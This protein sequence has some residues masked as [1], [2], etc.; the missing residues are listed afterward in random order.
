[1]FSDFDPAQSPIQQPFAAP[2]LPVAGDIVM[3]LSSGRPKVTM[4]LVRGTAVANGGAAPAPLSPWQE[5]NFIQFPRFDNLNGVKH[6]VAG[7]LIG[8]DVG[9]GSTGGR[10]YNFATQGTAP[11]GAGQLIGNSTGTGGAGLTLT[12]LSGPSISPNNTKIAVAGNDT[13][14]VIVF[15]YTAGDTM[16]S[17]ASLSGARQTASAPLVTGSS[18]GTAWLDD[19]TVLTLS[20]IGELYEVNATSMA[21]TLKTT[22]VTGS[23]TSRGTSLAYNPDVSPYLYAMYGGFTSPNTNNQLYILDPANSYN[24]VKQV[25]L[26]VSAS[27]ARDI[28]LDKD[29]N[30]FI[31]QNGSKLDFL[32]DVKTNPAGLTD[33][34]SVDWYTGAVYASSNGFDIG[35]APPAGVPGDYNDDG[36]VDAADYVLW[37]K[38]GPLANEVATI[39]STTPEDYTEWRARFGN[40]PGAGAGLGGNAAVPEPGAVLLMLLGV[41]AVGGRRR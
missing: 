41:A 3:G 13:G 40:P 16:G 36:K 12:R 9:T 34:S 8:V 10:I 38:G 11:L 23:E 27:T 30:L 20:V 24:L 19:N 33:D 29:G 14:K 32:F 22:L 7:N 4:D 39:G 25:S 18:Q 28:A 1:M 26:N 6:N 5:T 17:G 37:R 2:V 21:S 31:S 15:D 35:F